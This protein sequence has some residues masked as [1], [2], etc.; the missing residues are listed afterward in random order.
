MVRIGLKY[1]LREGYG[2]KARGRLRMKGW[3]E[4]VRGGVIERKLV[5]TRQYLGRE[6]APVIHS[7]CLGSA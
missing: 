1:G 6:K 3:L 5:E 4:G 2:V 7:F